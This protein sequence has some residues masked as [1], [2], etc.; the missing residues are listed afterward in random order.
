M[1]NSTLTIFYDGNCPLCTLEMQKLKHLDTKALIVLENLHQEN[2]DALFPQI[3][4]DKAMKILHAQYQGQVLLALDVTHRAWTLVGRGA[5]V[6][7]LQFPIIKQLA[8]AGYLLLAK[9]RHPI[10]HCLYQR[11]GIGI[12]ICE[13][14]TCYDQENH[15]DHR[16]K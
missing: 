7:P 1:T 5:L 3:N 9:Y 2:F 13:Q 10:S 14:G 6:A 15:I 4:F 11:F 12:K 16:R 8:H